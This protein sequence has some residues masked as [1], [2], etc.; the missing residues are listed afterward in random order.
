MPPIDPIHLRS[1][2]KLWPNRRHES[3]W[4]KDV[5]C[6]MGFHRWYLIDLSTL[7]SGAKYSF[8]RWCPKI[9]LD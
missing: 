2:E 3:N 4:L 5:L 1:L 9:K 8:C 7:P 6:A